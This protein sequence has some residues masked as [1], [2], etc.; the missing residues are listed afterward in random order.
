L[1]RELNPAAFDLGYSIKI[2]FEMVDDFG[3]LKKAQD[4][5]VKQMRDAMDRE[6]METMW[7][8]PTRGPWVTWG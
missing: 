4:R 2:P 3:V 7:G 1:S 5:L 8:S 6:I